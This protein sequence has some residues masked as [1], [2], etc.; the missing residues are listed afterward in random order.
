M[1][2][3]C[4]DCGFVNEDSRIYCGSCGELLDP[5]LRL[6]KDLENQTSG[7]KKPAYKAPPSRR[8]PIPPKNV[9]D[10][11]YIPP[12]TVREKKSSPVPWIILGLAAVAVVLY[13]VLSYAV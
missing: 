2:K 7:P 6:I 3:R 1:S 8:E 4:P 9:F 13:F 5:E 10:E 11:N 12:K